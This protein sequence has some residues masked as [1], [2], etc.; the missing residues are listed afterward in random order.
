MSF[1]SFI[2]RKMTKAVFALFLLAGM[3]TIFYATVTKSSIQEES[4]G[5]HAYPD[6]HA[7]SNKDKDK[8]ERQ[9]K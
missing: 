9:R 4:A 2:R 5:V 7:T 1:G 6:D 8:N 3:V